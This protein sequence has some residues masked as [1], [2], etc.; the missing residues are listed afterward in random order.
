MTLSRWCDMKNKSGMLAAAMLAGFASATI[1]FGGSHNPAFASNTGGHNP[2]YSLNH[3][4]HHLTYS[5]NHGGHGPTNPR[6]NGST[7][8]PQSTLPIAGAT[9]SPDA[10]R[11]VAAAYLEAMARLDTSA[12]N[13]QPITRML[14][15]ER[16]KKDTLIASKIQN[17][18]KHVTV[19]ANKP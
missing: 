4:G 5:S 2:T 8:N 13:D 1:A 7:G 6:G 18:P 16:L 19:A 9:M 14:S 12:A 15:K 11:D 3:G 10:E 17:L